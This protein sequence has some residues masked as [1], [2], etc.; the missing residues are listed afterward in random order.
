MISVYIGSRSEAGGITRCI[1]GEDGQLKM[2]ENYPCGSTAYM[3][4]EG[5]SFYALLRE[6]F[7]MSGG[8]ENYRILPGG[9]LGKT[10]G[11]YSVHGT[12][13][14]YVYAKNGNV[15]CANYINGTVIRLPDKLLAFGGSGPVEGRQASSHPHCIT[16]TPDG[17][18]LCICDLGA[19]RI[20]IVTTELEEVSEAAL[21][22]GSGPRHMVFSADGRHAFCSCELSST[23]C[24][25]E[26]SDG[27]LRYLRQ[28]SALP[29]NYAGES[30]CGGIRLSQD[31]SGLYVSNRGHDS[32]AVFSVNGGELKL[33]GHVMSGGSSPRD[34]CL[35]GHFLLCGNELS[36][37]VTVFDLSY[38]IP[39]SPVCVFRT[40]RPWCIMADDKTP[41]T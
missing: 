32:V 39:D 4:T 38:G 2:A 31:G 17:L 29:E 6:P 1:L 33:R 21:P 20:H 27:Q 25:L 26:Y 28:Y 24:V 36:D 14:A 34:F 7:Q 19:D 37:S 9:A 30:S 41:R 10:G 23:V 22:A 40:D 3:C 18:Y 35:A 5:D 15:W 12:V 8:L 11:P 16:P 13:P